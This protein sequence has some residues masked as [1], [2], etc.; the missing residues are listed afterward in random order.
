MTLCWQATILIFSPSNPMQPGPIYF[1]AQRKCSIFG[2]CCEAIPR[3]VN[4][5]IDD[6]VDCGK[7]ANYIILPD[8]RIDGHILIDY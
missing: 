6:I 1:L 5:I 3:Q 8:F 7:D 2:V 4:F